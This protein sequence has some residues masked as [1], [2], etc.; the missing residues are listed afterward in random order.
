MALGQERAASGD[1]LRVETLSQVLR[2]LLAAAV[3]ID[4]E[5]EINGARAIAQLSK[6]IGIQMRAQRAGD[7]AKTRL[8]QHGIVEQPLDKNHLGTLLSG[9]SWITS[10]GIEGEVENTSHATLGLNAGPKFF[11]TMGIP[12]M[13]G[14]VFTPQDFSLPPDT[15]WEPAVINEAFARTFFKDRNPLGRR[16]TGV[17]HQ[18]SSREIVGIVG[19]TKFRTLRS[20]IAPTLFVPAGG[21][22]AV[23][24]IRTAVD[25]RTI[26]PAVRSAVSQLDNNLPLFSMKTESEQI[27]RSLFEERLI[28]RLSSF[29]GALS[30]LLACVGLYGLLSYEVTQRTREIGIRMALGARPPDV[31]RIV[32]RQGV[33]LSAVGAI[34]GILVALGATRHLASL[35]YGVHPFDPPTFLAVAL[36]LSLVALAA[37]YIPARRA[38][39]VDPLVALR[40]E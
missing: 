27:E 1:A 2:G 17:G 29:F 6:L 37:C 38:S 40:Y 20:E 10:F 35:L 15:K 23:F 13:A 9:N 31:L 7:V 5:G 21:G 22:E 14:R 36:L 19:D 18:G 26:I 24:E 12:L 39:R 11:E 16:L 4:I 28:A 33:G 25:P 34:I 30:L 3:G 32:V 8:P